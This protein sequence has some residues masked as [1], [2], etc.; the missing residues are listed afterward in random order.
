MLQSLGDVN[1]VPLVGISFQSFFPMTLIVLCLFNVF[2]VYG[3]I[4]TG[5]GIS[6]FEFSEKFS[7]EKIEDG[8]RLLHNGNEINRFVFS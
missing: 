8:K 5:L 6:R 3:R 7:N 2:D 1:L 4:L